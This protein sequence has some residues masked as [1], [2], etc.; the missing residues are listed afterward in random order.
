MAMLNRRAVYLFALAA[1]TLFYILYPLWIAQFIWVAVLLLLP[2]DLLISLPGML[3]RRISLIAPDVLMQGE[4]ANLVITTTSKAP[5]P[6]G[7][8]KTRLAISQN[9]VTAVNPTSIKRMEKRPPVKGWEAPRHLG[10]KC[11]PQQG[12]QVLVPVDTT[13]CD[14]LLFEVRRFWICSIMGLF[15]LPIS[16]NC[17]TKVVVLPAPAKPPLSVLLDEMHEFFPNPGSGYSEDYDL[18]SYRIGDPINTMHWKLSA[19]HDSP[20]TR[21]QVGSPL[22]NRLLSLATWEGLDERDLILGRLYWCSTFLLEQGLSHYIRVGSSDA[23]TAVSQPDHLIF[24]LCRLL[25]GEELP[26]AP[27][28]PRDYS[29]VLFIDAREAD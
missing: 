21:E 19:K 24:F 6:S 27:V 29:W 13:R 26:F 7:L 16:A 9:A 28:S 23:V 15:A 5:F 11:N 2:F 18:R 12:S 3:T 10:L 1:S 20:I 25:L 14:V 22:H 4:S 17:Q 8:I